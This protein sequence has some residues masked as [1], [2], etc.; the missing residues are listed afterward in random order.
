M[1][2]P[3]DQRRI[4]D[5]PRLRPYRC[6]IIASITF[7][8]VVERPGWCAAELDMGHQSAKRRKNCR[9]GEAR[10][11]PSHGAL[12]FRRS[13]LAVFRYRFRASV[14]GI[15]SGEACSELLAA[16]VVVPVRAVSGPP[17]PAVTSRGRRTPNL[18]PLQDR[19]ENTAP[20]ER[21]KGFLRQPH[22]EVN[23]YLQS[24]SICNV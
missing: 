11:A 8:G 19:L 15:A 16:R 18:T 24:A 14:P 13:T 10:R 20:H 6:T 21:D 5:V 2:E 3:A 23:I 1:R 7:H 12:A 17:E 4:T 22:S 9:A